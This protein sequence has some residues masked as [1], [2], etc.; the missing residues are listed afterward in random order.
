MIIVN[1]VAIF[2]YLIYVFKTKKSQLIHLIPFAIISIVC[3]YILISSPGNKF[4]LEST[5]VTRDFEYYTNV[6]VKGSTYIF[7]TTYGWLLNNTLIIPFAI[8]IS[9]LFIDNTFKISNKVLILIIFALLSLIYI[10]PFISFISIGVSSAERIFNF[11]NWF[12][13]VILFLLIPL[14]I[15]N[16]IEA[17]K[18]KALKAKPILININ[19]FL[20]IAYLAFS[21]NNFGLISH[22][23]ISGEYKEYK[24]EMENR[25]QIIEIAKQNKNWSSATIDTL[26][27]K[28]ITIYFDDVVA[29]KTSKLWNTS[30]E[31]YFNI[32]ELKIKNDT[33]FKINIIKNVKK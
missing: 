30:Y 22:E 33:I 3:I 28:P 10:L 18:Q 4:R 31:S 24:K 23:F 2:C 29:N 17:I 1:L 5:D 21:S 26:I 16:N 32:D 27:H 25:Y 6:L 11:T 9:Y 20:I 15:T 12:F 7:S 19:I 14:L 13:L 8:I